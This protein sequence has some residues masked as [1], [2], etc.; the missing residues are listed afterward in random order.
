MDLA[1]AELPAGRDTV[2]L[3]ASKL[4]QLEAHRTA[5]SV[6]RRLANSGAM[7]TAT[8]QEY[9]DKCLRALARSVRACITEE[10]LRDAE[11]AGGFRSNCRC[12]G[13][14]LQARCWR[15]GPAGWPR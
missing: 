6:Y 4:S 7:D 14:A 8:A 1:G 12:A 11:Q 13:S 3:A 9:I 5:A 2:A 10:R 15:R